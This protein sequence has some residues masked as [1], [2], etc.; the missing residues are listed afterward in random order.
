MTATFQ[1]DQTQYR[2]VEANTADNGTA[3]YERYLSGASGPD[4][5]GMISRSLRIGREVQRIKLWV[6]AERLPVENSVISLPASTK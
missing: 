4:Y 2:L 3:V 1:K 6:C 5:L